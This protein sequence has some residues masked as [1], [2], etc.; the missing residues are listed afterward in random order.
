[1][2]GTRQIGDGSYLAKTPENLPSGEDARAELNE[3][4]SGRSRLMSTPSNTHFNVN[5]SYQQ[6]L[7]LREP[8]E[9]R[10]APSK[11]EASQS[12]YH[13]PTLKA[14]RRYQ[15]GVDISSNPKLLE[16]LAGMEANITRRLDNSNQLANSALELADRVRGAQRADTRALSELRED[17]SRL[18]RRFLDMQHANHETL[19][20]ILQY[21]MQNINEI[22]TVSA[23]NTN[24]LEDIQK[25]VGSVAEGVSSIKEEVAALKE[26][27]KHPKTGDGSTG[28]ILRRML[29]KPKRPTN[30]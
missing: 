16:L 26:G 4:V 6:H 1:M 20:Y 9:I 12:N 8:L 30:P 11:I 17:N 10:S 5:A 14:G 21:T 27:P 13:L 29:G 2:Q 23:E 3:P 19:H 15:R 24:K 18:M 28:S 7:N 25:C 22:R